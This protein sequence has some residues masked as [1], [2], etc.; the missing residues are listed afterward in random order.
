MI[1]FANETHTHK[2]RR[3]SYLHSCMGDHLTALLHY[4]GVL[5][6]SSPRVFWHWQSPSILMYTTGKVCY[7]FASC[8]EGSRSKVHILEFLFTFLVATLEA[9]MLDCREHS[10]PGQQIEKKRENRDERASE[11]HTYV[12]SGEA[13][14]LSPRE[15]YSLSFASLALHLVL[16]VRSASLCAHPTAA[17]APGM[18]VTHCSRH[19][20]PHPPLLLL[21]VACAPVQ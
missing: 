18:D 11:Q 5:L 1:T 19:H 17:A 16:A 20:S 12:T 10:I 4:C 6:S 9:T 15:R 2:K 21:L 3:F 14:S 7:S 13:P 8:V